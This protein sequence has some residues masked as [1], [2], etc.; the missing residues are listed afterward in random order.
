MSL[1]PYKINVL[2][3]MFCQSMESIESQTFAFS[4]YICERMCSMHT[5]DNPIVLI[6]SQNMENILKCL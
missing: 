6:C 1:S 4:F 2:T 5:E 3:K